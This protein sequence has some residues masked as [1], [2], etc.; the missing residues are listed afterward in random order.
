MGFWGEIVTANW[1]MLFFQ[2]LFLQLEYSLS[3]A[4]KVVTYL[5]RKIVTYLLFLGLG[6]SLA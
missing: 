2:D 6:R 1:N 5:S 3:Q 4:E